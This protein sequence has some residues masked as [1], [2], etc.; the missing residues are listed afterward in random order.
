MI[1]SRTSRRKRCAD[2]G[3]LIA[4]KVYH[5][6]DLTGPGVRF[7]PRCEDCWRKYWD[8]AQGVDQ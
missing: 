2:C 3:L 4:G 7:V 1:G 8:A 6:P 5:Q